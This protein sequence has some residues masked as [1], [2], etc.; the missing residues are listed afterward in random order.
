MEIKETAELCLS[1]RQATHAW[2][3]ESDDAFE[4]IVRVWHDCLKDVPFDMAKKALNEYLV[5]N[6]YPPTIAD[7]YK[8]Y[9]EYLENRKEKNKQLREI[10]YRTIAYYPCYTDTP[11]IQN[12][13]MRITGNDIEV[14]LRFERWLIDFVRQS[15]ISNADFKPF[16]E[17]MKGVKQIE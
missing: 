1:I 16:E 5:N 11:E 8:P 15:E 17:F 6:T 9:K 12:E 7:I 13:W 14:A 10:Y 4:Q 3:K 2:A